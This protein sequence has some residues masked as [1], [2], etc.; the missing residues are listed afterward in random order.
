VIPQHIVSTNFG[1]SIRKEFYCIEL[2]IGN[3]TGSD[4]QLAGIGFE[5]PQVAYQDDGS[6]GNANGRS[7]KYVPKKNNGIT[8][9][10]PVMETVRDASGIPQLNTDGTPRRRVAYDS[11]GNEKFEIAGILPV[12]SYATVRGVLAERQLTHPRAITLASANAL[13]ELLGGFKPFFVNP[14]H[15]NHFSNWVNIVS[16]P[17]AKGIENVWKDA[18]PGELDRLD[19]QTLRDDKII[20]N[21]TTYK[22]RVFIPKDALFVHGEKDRDDVREVRRRL[23]VLLLVGHIIERKGFVNRQRFGPTPTAQ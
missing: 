11:D 9:F 4:L 14:I 8:E 21:N 3:N 7:K 13:G 22:T 16:N 23:G 12:S 20:G 2:V 15:G 1:R 10:A 19:Q 6:R 18:Y 5:I 17:L